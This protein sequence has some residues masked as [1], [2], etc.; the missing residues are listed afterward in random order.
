MEEPR[1]TWSML[2]SGVEALFPPRGSSIIGIKKGEAPL[3]MSRSPSVFFR[4][5]SGKWRL[6]LALERDADDWNCISDGDHHRVYRWICVQSG[7]NLL[8]AFHNSFEKCLI[9]FQLEIDNEKL[10][11]D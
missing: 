4:R 8:P 11:Y 3:L 6:F 2:Q 9:L 7:V 1:E 10:V 5:A